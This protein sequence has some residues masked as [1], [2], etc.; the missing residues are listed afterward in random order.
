MQN[1]IQINPI[2]HYLIFN[3]PVVRRL[4]KPLVVG[5]IILLGVFTPHASTTISHATEVLALLGLIG[6][7]WGMKIIFINRMFKG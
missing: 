6:L 7:V 4:F 2:T 3:R 1:K 5:M